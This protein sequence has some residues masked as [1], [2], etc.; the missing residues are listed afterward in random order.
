M[1][2]PEQY[3]RDEMSQRVTATMV[4][5]AAAGLIAMAG[6]YGAM[7]GGDTVFSPLPMT[8][9]IP[10]GMAEYY[11]Y[12]YLGWQLNASWMTAVFPAFLYL[13][14]T[15]PPSWRSRHVPRLSIGIFILA[16]LGTFLYFTL[17]W[18][19]G[20]THQ[21]V[22]HTALL[23]IMN[24]VAVAGLASLLRAQSHRPRYVFHFLYQTALFLW[25]AWFSFPYLG[26][27]I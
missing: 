13:L 23:M 21:G 8:T 5:L 25:L 1:T 22:R 17:L 14:A 2:I 4:W 16:S 11:G 10:T 12:K 18:R 27:G 26:E 15:L 7:G 19:A 20:V 9:F 24:L 3:R 6:W